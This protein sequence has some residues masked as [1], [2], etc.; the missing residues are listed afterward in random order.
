MEIPEGQNNKFNFFEGSVDELRL[1]R[2]K[3]SREKIIANM[4]YPNCPYF[5]PNCTQIEGY[6]HKLECNECIEPRILDEEKMCVCREGFKDGEYGDN[7]CYRIPVE[8]KT[9]EL[10]IYF[11]FDDG[12]KDISL[13]G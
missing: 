4:N 12:V 3:L 11:S 2:K 7:E 5:C 1:Y 6:E 8:I 10:K 13:T 9:E